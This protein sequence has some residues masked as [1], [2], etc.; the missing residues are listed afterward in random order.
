ML[1]LTLTLNTR[2]QSL[3]PKKKPSPKKSPNRI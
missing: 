2:Q 1:T 3:G